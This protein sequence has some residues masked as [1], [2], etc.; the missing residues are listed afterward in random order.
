LKL[1]LG[2][3]NPEMIAAWT[4]CFS[5]QPNVTVRGGNILMTTADALVSPANSFGFMDG[6]LDWSISELFEWRIQAIVQK[7]IQTKHHGELVVG[8][9][10]IVETGHERFRYLVCAPT[11][12]TPQ[13]VSSTM[14]AYLA[15]RA[16]LLAIARHNAETKDPINSVSIPGLCTGVGRLPYDCCARQMRAAYDHVMGLRSNKFK[17][18]AE[19]STEERALKV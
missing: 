18:L 3:K 13:N 16:I 19:A 5:D 1:I 6:G 8:A 17:S 9:A 4:A 7:A 14:N 11:M 12:R 15:M 10:E 2:D